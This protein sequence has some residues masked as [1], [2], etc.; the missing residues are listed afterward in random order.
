MLDDPSNYNAND[1]P[2]IARNLIEL[3]LILI[4]TERDRQEAAD[5]RRDEADKERD[6]QMQL[7]MDHVRGG[8]STHPTPTTQDP[9]GVAPHILKGGMTYASRVTQRMTQRIAQPKIAPPPRADL[10][11][12]QPSKAII[13]SN[14][15]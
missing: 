1:D 6:E 2:L 13:H 4:R 14:T 11:M 3:V 7:L 12:F 5:E 9:I 8:L 10:R 15:R